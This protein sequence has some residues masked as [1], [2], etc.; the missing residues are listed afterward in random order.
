MNNIIILKE[1]IKSFKKHNEL[2]CN[3]DYL[4]GF[5]S[6]VQLTKLYNLTFDDIE[7]S[8]VDGA[9]DGGID[10]FIILVDDM[11]IIT[12]EQIEEISI[13]DI[14]TIKLIIIQSKNNENFKESVLDKIY[15]SITQIYNLEKKEDTLG[16]TF[17]DTLVE[18][19]LLFRALWLKAVV[20]RSNI[21][22]E[23]FYT[24]FS[25]EI[26]ETEAFKS[27]VDTLLKATQK[28]IP[29]CKVS[30][31]NYSAKE[32]LSL[33][34]LREETE[35]KIKLKQTPL[36]VN[37]SVDSIGYIGVV[38]IPEYYKFI[39]DSDD[40]LREGIFEDNIRHFQGEVDVNKSIK[41]T[42]ENDTERDFWWLNNGITIISSDVSPFGNTLS[43]K[44]V[45]IVNGLQTSY[46]IG[47]FYKNIPNDSRSILL[48]II[49][50]SDKK[51][52]DKIISATNRQTPINPA[53]LKSTDETQRN[54]EM[55]FLQKDYFYDRR[56]NFYKNQGKPASKIFSIQNT[57]QA[58]HS[59]KN[60]KPSE[61]RAKP[62]T[63]IKTDETY[64]KIFVPTIDY[65]VYLN[66]CIISKSVT[67]FIKNNIPTKEEKSIVR[68]LQY[69]L[70]RSV[71]SFVYKK[72]HVSVKEIKS[73]DLELVTDSLI[74]D[75]NKFIL[76]CF[77]EYIKEPESKTQ[78]LDSISKSG[79]FEKYLDS[80]LI[81]KYKIKT[82]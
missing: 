73:I 24:C 28:K 66:C 58:I 56:K 27:K 39:T 26:H 75:T 9:L 60:F 79:R 34:N 55:Y 13:S 37:Y 20:E 19:I 50:N 3:D 54:I 8:T 82:V 1:C 33:Y 52:I 70:L 15:I 40:N 45:Q 30:Y 46:T 42:L 78:N 2:T 38:S 81:E 67:N 59:I 5:F 43:L 47:K 22:V 41:S 63:L 74:N 35:L 23:Y 29:Q 16:K 71:L 11:P 36:P 64:N 18:K 77:N 12:K 62:T 61:A 49:V 72:S 44:D 6:V 14:S 51:T 76:F 7:D 17:N 31:K 25:D 32:L 10:N 48:K 80:K 69:H 57:A 21:E 4:F 53:L 65:Q 68:G